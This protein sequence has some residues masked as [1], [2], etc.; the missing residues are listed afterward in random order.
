M[1]IS[2]DSE[3]AFDKVQH[4]FIIKVLERLQIK[5]AY[6]NI[7]KAT[8]RKPIANIYL[9]G[10]KHKVY[11]TEMRNKRRLSTLSISIQYNT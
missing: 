1:I 2:S 3:K 11:S 5:R 10:E 4:L 6:L 9:N 7:I 8:Y